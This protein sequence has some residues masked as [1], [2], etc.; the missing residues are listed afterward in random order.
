VT[1]QK[2]YFTPNSSLA[3]NAFCH[4]FMADLDGYSRNSDGTFSSFA[5]QAQMPGDRNMPG[6][7]G[8]PVAMAV[9]PNGQFFAAYF[10]TELSRSSN[11]RLCMFSI[12]ADGTLSPLPGSPWRQ[13]QFGSDLVWNSS[14]EYLIA[15]EHDGIHVLYL[16]CQRS[17]NPGCRHWKRRN[18]ARSF[19]SSEASAVRD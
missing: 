11:A 3:Y 7:I 19:R 12:N 13:V 15:A 14:G 17:S 4:H 16:G 10:D 2:F 5:T 9:S 18:R 1:A 8:C 6:D